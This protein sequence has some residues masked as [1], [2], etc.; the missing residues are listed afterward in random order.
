M[1]KSILLKRLEERFFLIQVAG[2]SCA[3]PLVVGICWTCA[4]FFQA[5]WG[6]DFWKTFFSLTGVTL[7]SGG[8]AAPVL[9]YIVE[10]GVIRNRAISNIRYTILRIVLFGLMSIPI[11]F[12]EQFIVKTLVGGYQENLNSIFFV[13]SLI[14][15]TYV[16]ISLTFLERAAAEFRSRE[17]MYK[18][19]IEALKFEIDEAKREKDISQIIDNESFI[20]LKAKAQAMKARH[21][22]K[23]GNTKTL[24]ESDLA[25]G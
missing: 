12:I 10:R 17:E 1:M 13:M 3:I 11:G 15:C 20:D 9:F 23:S 4:S 14:V 7:L 19:Q 18:R 22:T 5:G 8:I 21:S 24:T 16:A 25:Q 6:L 2:Y